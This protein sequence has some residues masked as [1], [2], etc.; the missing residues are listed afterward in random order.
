LPEQVLF[1]F[2]RSEID[3]RE[4]A[5]GDFSV[6]RHRE[7]GADERAGNTRPNVALPL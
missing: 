3:R 4:I 7:R 6:H 1:V 5:G 2:A